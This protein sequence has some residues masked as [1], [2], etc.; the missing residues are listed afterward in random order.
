MK[1]IIVL[2]LALLGFSSCAKL[3]EVEFD[4][5]IKRPNIEIDV[6]PSIW[7]TIPPTDNNIDFEINKKL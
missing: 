1:A 5:H 2:C 7:D 4:E 3:H 6:P